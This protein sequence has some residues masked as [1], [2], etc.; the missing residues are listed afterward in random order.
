[1]LIFIQY[2]TGDL[3]KEFDLKHGHQDKE[4]ADFIDIE[5]VLRYIILYDKHEYNDRRFRAQLVC[6][7]LL[8]AE[9]GGRLGAICQSSS[10]HET[11]SSLLYQVNN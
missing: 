11:N 2:I 3:A 9:D 10:Y 7:F 5:I 8:I 4:V 1:M 6:I